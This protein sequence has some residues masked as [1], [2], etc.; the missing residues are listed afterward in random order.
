MKPALVVAGLAVAV[1]AVYVLRLDAA[2]GLMVDDAWYIVL[3]Q[4]LAEGSGYRL[5]SSATAPILPAF[6]P[7]FPLL[8][9]P[10]VKAFPEFPANVPALKA[11][12]LL[13]MLGVA[14]AIY[15]HLVRQRSVERPVAMVVA[16]ST[17]LMPAFVFLATSAVMAEAVFTLGQLCVVLAIERAARQ[18]AAGDRYTIIGAVLAGCTMLVRVAGVATAA[19]AIVYLIY[20]RGWRPALLFAAFAGACYMPWVIYAAANRGNPEDQ[21]RHGGTIAH[22]YGAL[23]QLRHGGEPGTG[24][25][26]LGDLPR[27]VFDNVVNVAGRDIGAMIL[28]AVYR[29]PSESGQEVFGMTGDTGFRASSMGGSSGTVAVSAAVALVVATG[30][31]AAARRQLTVAELVVALSL[32]MVALVPARTFRY[33]LPL[34]PFVVFYFLCGVESLSRLVSRARDWRFGAA[35]RVA[36]ACV[37]ALF[38]AEHVQYVR[39]MSSS[40]PPVWVQEQAEV[41]GLTSWLAANVDKG[42]VASNNPGLVYLATGLK[43]VSMGDAEGNW[44]SWQRLD[45][46]YGVAVHPADKL[47]EHMTQ[48]ILFESA[49]GRRWV[50]ELKP[51]LTESDRRN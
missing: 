27:R 30:F 14:V 22:S 31:I 43:G 16:V 45:V 21:I 20:R 6:P 49:H 40:T 11:L 38:S 28:P 23:L 35:F 36:S 10:I 46:R 51:R 8:L 24:A 25:V 5:I 18:P 34:A 3:A 33:V 15:A 39:S 37:L 44:P 26:G 12:S 13:S 1:S 19:A 41:N 50:T 32:G 29:G 47:P 4:S 48:T 9:A 17:V 7:G 42:G 2:A